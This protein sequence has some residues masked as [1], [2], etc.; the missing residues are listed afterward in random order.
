MHPNRYVGARETLKGS[1]PAASSRNFLY[2]TFHAGG[3][4][5]KTFSAVP[6]H[7]ET[8]DGRYDG[9]RPKR[10]PVRKPTSSLI[11]LPAIRPAFPLYIVT[12]I[13]I[14]TEGSRLD[15]R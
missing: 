12:I 2:S 9:D 5:H 13:T 3:V 10:T 14:V 6:R 8:G 11:A 4:G 1:Y 15:K 7:E